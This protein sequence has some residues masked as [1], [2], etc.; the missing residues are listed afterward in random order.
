MT[1]APAIRLMPARCFSRK[2]PTKLAAIPNVNYRPISE[3]RFTVFQ[4][5]EFNNSRIF[6]SG[7]AQE[8]LQSLVRQGINITDLVRQLRFARRGPGQHDRVEAEL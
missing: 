8:Y 6:Q 5:F 7:S 1:T 3:V 2:P 4:S